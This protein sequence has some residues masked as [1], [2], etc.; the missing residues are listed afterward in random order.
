MGIGIIDP[1]PR[2]PIPIIQDCTKDCLISMMTLVLTF[3]MWQD[4][5]CI[6]TSLSLT[7]KVERKRGGL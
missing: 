1:I 7:L 2:L 5:L 3:S 6:P 4:S